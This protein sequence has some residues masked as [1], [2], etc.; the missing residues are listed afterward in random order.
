MNFA[1][2]P[3][4]RCTSHQQCHHQV[5]VILRE[6]C[7][8]IVQIHGVPHSASEAGCQQ[9]TGLHSRW[10]TI[11]AGCCGKKALWKASTI[12]ETMS[13]G[14]VETGPFQGQFMGLKM[15]IHKIQMFENQ[16]QICVI[17]RK[18]DLMPSR[19]HSP[20]QANL[21]DA[22]LR[23]NGKCVL[24]LRIFRKAMPCP[25]VQCRSAERSG[26][27]AK[28]N[29]QQKL[30]VLFSLLDVIECWL[31][32]GNFSRTKTS[33]TLVGMRMGCEESS[34]C[35]KS[36]TRKSVVQRGAVTQLWISA[37]AGFLFKC[38]KDFD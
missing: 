1:G 24:L 25:E 38:V 16:N 27:C 35:C 11:L 12:G 5:P 21:W 33:N 20:I 26:D 18:V 22:H 29:G 4:R 3:V 31:K 17:Q 8:D 28:R 2:S 23:N 7:M 10:Q 32:I 37:V 13:N 30:L 6:Q 9:K 15:G 19:M 36:C 34:I 14:V